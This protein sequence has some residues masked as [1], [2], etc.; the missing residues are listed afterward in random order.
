VRA[1]LVATAFELGARHEK[2]ET[3]LVGHNATNRVLIL[4]AL[5]LGSKR[6]RRIGQDM[7]AVNVVTVDGGI[8]TVITLKD[9]A[10]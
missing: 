1:R 5:G 4:A 2:E 7:A 3:V 8:L 6:F 9:T 10:I